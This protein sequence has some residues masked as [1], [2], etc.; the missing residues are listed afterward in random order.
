MLLGA[1]AF[2]NT[3]D[4]I[5]FAGLFMLAVTI[6]NMRRLGPARGAASAVA[7]LGPV[8]LVAAV[9]YAPWYIDFRSQASGLEPYVGEGTRPAHTF[10]QFG[11]FVLLAVASSL[12]ALWEP[13]RS[14]ALAVAPFTIWVAVVPL[15]VW[16]VLPSGTLKPGTTDEF[17]GLGDAVDARGAGGFVTL[18]VLALLVWTSVTVAVAGVLMRHPIGPVAGLASGGVLLLFGSELFLIKD[19]FFGGV[20]RLNTVFKLTYQAWILMSVAGAVSV[21]AVWDQLRGSVA[22]RTAFA[23]PVTAVVAFGLIYAVIAVPARSNGFAP[24]PDIDGLAFLAQTDPAEYA[25]L[26]WLRENA[27]GGDVVIEATG[28]RWQT[29]GDGVPELVDGGVDYGPGGR[30]SARTGLQTPIGWFSHEDQ[31]RGSTPEWRAEFARRQDLVDRLYTGGGDAQALMVELGA[32]YLVV[33]TLELTRYPAVSL[34]DFAQ[35]LDLVF[36][37]G[38]ARVYALPE[39]EFRGS[40]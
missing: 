23:V 24:E 14:K 27:D 2:T 29:G 38:S 37:Q 1:L 12:F 6:R 10:L 25:L 20:P 15:L 13:L 9:V 31:W 40:E 39:L 32:R 26:D 30:I 36:E 3:W 11:P 21:V 5:T 28:R 7:F 8:V 35:A 18:T 19:V 16:L 33:S 4:L 17:V 22:A 34:P